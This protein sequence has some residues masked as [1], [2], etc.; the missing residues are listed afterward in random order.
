MCTPDYHVGSLIYS[1]GEASLQGGAEGPLA[2]G[3]VAEASND[4]HTYVSLNILE[5]Q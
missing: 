2:E 4:I 5:G 3:A 1:P